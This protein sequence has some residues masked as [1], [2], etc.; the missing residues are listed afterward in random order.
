MNLEKS[1]DKLYKIL[2]IIGSLICIVFFG[3]A[4]IEENFLRE[5][6]N[7]QTAYKQIL[8]SKAKND[9]QKEIA[10]EFPVKIRQVILKDFDRVDR[11]VSCHT[12]IENPQMAD[13]VPPFAAHPGDYV[14][15]HPVEKFGCSICHGGQDRALSAKSV[16]ARQ[17]DV[18][19]EYPVLRKE[20]IQSS[21]GKCHLSVFNKGQKLAGADILM[22]GRE[23]FYREGCLGC[24][25]V[26][27]VGGSVGLELTEEG[28]KTRH[29]YS[30]KNIED[31]HTVPNWLLE[32]FLNPQKVSGISEMPPIRLEP[33]EMDALI[34]FVMGLHVPKYPSEYYSLDEIGEFRGLRPQLSGQEA[35]NLICKVCHGENG[36]GKDYRVFQASVPALNNQ[37]FLAM[38][39]E[40]MIKFT[41]RHGR[42]GRAMS[43]WKKSNGGLS[44][45]EIDE[46]VKL[47]RSW[48]IQ[49]PAFSAVKSARGDVRLGDKL[50]RSR[51]GTC[52]GLNGEG[53]IGPSLNNQD[54][55]SLATDK[56]LYETITGGR[57]NTAMPS[58]SQLSKNEIA[59]LIAKL[60]SWQKVPQIALSSN[61]IDGDVANGQILFKQMCVGCHGLHGQG[62]VGTAI[63]NKDFLAAAS[64]QFILRSIS[65]GRGQSAMRSW[66]KRFQGIEQLSNRD[67]H[68]IVAFI[69]SRENATSDAIYTNISPGTPARGKVLFEGMCSGCHGM[70]GEGKHGPALNNQEFLSAAT[71]G[72]LQATIAI[73]RRGTAMRSWAKGAQGYEELSA[74]NINDIVSYIRSW[75]RDVIPISN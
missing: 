63:L 1:Y 69:R 57:R 60:R 34:T 28:N 42:S 61:K 54:F 30:F 68:D 16:F 55:L 50:F 73:G 59:S 20:Y 23:V 10:K 32:H 47:I 62:T 75:Q 35:Y 18:H 12:G 64:D 56:F 8:M 51:C 41:I 6:K 37:D 15:N 74:D 71:N 49:A 21:C 39:S 9:K 33:D 27:G 46:L 3:M 31:E 19:W 26:R 40:D 17:E 44:E 14:K 11:C 4:A 52:H 45:K 70:K 29:E 5:W 66:S 65:R 7:N 25:K 58:W 53:G 67:M 36:E 38:A 24:H 13:Q 22:K 43:S 72:F 2:T 48:K